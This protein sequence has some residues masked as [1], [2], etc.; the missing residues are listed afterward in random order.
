MKRRLAGK[1]GDRGIACFER[2]FEHT[3]GGQNPAPLGTLGKPL[4]VGIHR[5]IIMP[6]FLRWCRISSIHSI[7]SRDLQ[8]ASCQLASRLRNRPLEDTR[9]CD[10]DIIFHLL[11]FCPVGF[12]GNGC[13][14]FFMSPLDERPSKQ[15]YSWGTDWLVLEMR[16]TFLPINTYPFVASYRGVRL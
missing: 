15:P 6:G 12:K 8:T 7:I 3:V 4:F 2:P 11:A 14:V 16:K 5:R 1:N 13:S 9:L 10:L